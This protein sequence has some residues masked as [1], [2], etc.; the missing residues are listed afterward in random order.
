MACGCVPIVSDGGGLKDA[1][2]NAGIT[3]TRGNVNSLVENI[4]KVFTNPVL[5]AN[6][7]NA[8]NN[9]L[10]KHYPEVVS[11][12]YLRVIEDVMNN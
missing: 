10:T 1:V 7:R 5:E 2:G 9:H 11:Q 3:F 8:A 6:L 12:K 4:M